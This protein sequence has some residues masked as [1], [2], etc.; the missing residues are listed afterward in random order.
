MIDKLSKQEILEKLNNKN[1]EV[2]VLESTDST[3]AYLKRSIRDDLKEG[4]A[5]IADS[6]TLGKGRFSRKFYSPK[7]SGIYMSILLRPSLSPENAVLITAAAA[8]AVSRAIEKLSG[9]E[10]KIKWV[11][12]I[13]ISSKKVCGILTEG[14][15]NSDG[16]FNYAILGIGINAY[17]PENNFPNEIKDIAGA[18]FSQ[19]KENLRNTLIAEV[20]NNFFQYYNNLESKTFLDDYR[21]K[22]LVLGKEIKVPKNDKLFSA[23]ALEIDDNCRLLVEYDNN[24]REYL[25]SGEISIGVDF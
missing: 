22:S 18:I 9:K 10:T 17:K 2:T 4:F 5:I 24:E 1:I 20:I 12:D 7:N 23:K 25:S 14:S 8:V 15:I 21:Q 16:S 19:K 6:Q 13:Y 3:N 11:N